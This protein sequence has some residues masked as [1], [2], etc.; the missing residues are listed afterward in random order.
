MRMI[1]VARLAVAAVALFCG[2]PAS[3]LAQAAAARRASHALSAF[4]VAKAERLLRD[5][6]PCLGCHELG[7]DG[8]RIGPSLSNVGAR[9]SRD[10]IA[11]MI[12]DPQRIVPGTMMPKVRMSAATAA[13]IADYLSRRAR[14]QEPPAFAPPPSYGTPSG[15]PPGD[16]ATVYHRFCAPCHGLTGDGDGYN[17]PFLSVRPTAHASAAY[18]STRSDDALYDAI[19]GGGYIMNRS[20]RMPPFGGTLSAAQIRGLVAYLRT[21]CGCAGPAWSRDDR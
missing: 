5:R 20:A 3:A 16:P 18:M 10:H 15:T 2:M 14:S 12:G 8:G 7:G 11:A 1:G 19:A 4:A 21:L 17:A 9:R 13:L 6:L